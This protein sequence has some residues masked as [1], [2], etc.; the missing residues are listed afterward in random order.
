MG[1]RT[2]WQAGKWQKEK[3][4]EP[5]GA[6]PRPQ[7][8]AGLGWRSRYRRS[9]GLRLRLRRVRHHIVGEKRL[10]EIGLQ[11]IHDCRR[12][13]WSDR[14]PVAAPRARHNLSVGDESLAGM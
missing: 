3:R 2:A 14:H 7:G 5:F 13:Q 6:L 10:I 1:S 11:G 4:E 9:V 12:T 8:I